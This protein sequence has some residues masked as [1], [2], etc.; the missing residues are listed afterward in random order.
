M[1]NK[2]LKFTFL[3]LVLILSGLNLFIVFTGR[4]YLYKT[5]WYNFSNIDDGNIFPKR[6]IENGTPEPWKYS[7][8]F[9]KTALPDTLE[10][11]LTS[12]NTAATLVIKNDS[13]VFE[14]YW[15]GYT[16]SS[17]TNSFSI[18]KSMVSLLVGIAL[19][20]HKIN[21]LNDPVR[22]YLPEYK[23]NLGNNVTIKHLLTMSSGLNWDESYKNPLSMTTEAYYGSDLQSLIKKIYPIQ[24]PGEYFSYKSGDTQILGL[25]LMKLYNKS[26]SEILSEKIWKKIGAEHP[27]YWSLDK[28]N[29]IEKA[30]CCVNTNARDY[31]RLGK[32]MMNFG[33]WNNDTIVNKEYITEAITPNGLIDEETKQPIDYYGYQ[34][35]ILP[36]YKNHN[37]M[38]YA[39]GVNGQYV[40]VI[41]S[42]KTII[43]RLGDKRG[44]KVGKTVHHQE[45]FKLIDFAL[46]IK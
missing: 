11:Y 37:D 45:T 35:W 30:Y 41:P 13:V 12:L 19:N 4:F 2:T 25:M 3:F 44:E 7:K 9:N 5:I 34:W 23:H 26:L 38:F 24:K 20:E 22:K 42:E 39:R 17:Q 31:A 43:V 33:V 15:D 21:S 36:L 16:D 27:A 1:K 18:A 46:S 6:V 10:K 28:E 40:I 14:Q 8:K 29:G 32:L